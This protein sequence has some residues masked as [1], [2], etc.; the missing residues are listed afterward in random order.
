MSVE[1]QAAACWGSI[2]LMVQVPARS[3]KGKTAADH[4]TTLI[5][6]TGSFSLAE[7]KRGT[8]VLRLTAEGRKRLAHASKHHPI[9]AKL[10]LSIR[11]G[12]TAIKPVLAV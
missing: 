6:A 5:L 4:K 10:T 3:G 1:C 12:K 2:E 9:T 8:V 11:G 7:G